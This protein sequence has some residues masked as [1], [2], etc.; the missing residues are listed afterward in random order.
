MKI[1]PE[2]QLTLKWVLF[3]VGLLRNTKIGAAGEVQAK[4]QN[5]ENIEKKFK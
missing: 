5:S 3:N 1:Y 2:K 4:E